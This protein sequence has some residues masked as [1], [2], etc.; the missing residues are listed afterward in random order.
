MSFVFAFPFFCVPEIPPLPWVLGDPY[1]VSLALVSLHT[2]SWVN[3]ANLGDN[4]G[5]PFVVEV[6]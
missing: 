4:G 6:I 2:Q 3:I 5:S 1:L